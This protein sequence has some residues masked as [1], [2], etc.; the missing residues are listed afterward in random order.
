MAMAEATAE[1][2]HQHLWP[3]R[4]S[5]TLRIR[6]KISS[7]M[8]MR[9]PARAM[10]ESPAGDSKPSESE[11]YAEAKEPHPESDFPGNSQIISQK[12]PGTDSRARNQ[13]T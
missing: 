11:I 5:A 7:A 3:R 8:Q 10:Q 12:I 9:S 1:N 13:P 4:K 6:R 2:I